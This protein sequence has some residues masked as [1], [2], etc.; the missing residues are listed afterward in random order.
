MT[1]KQIL[2]NWV[3]NRNTNT[4]ILENT[5]VLPFHMVEGRQMSHFYSLTNGVAEP[6]SGLG[7]VEGNHVHPFPGNKTFPSDA[8]SRLGIVHCRCVFGACKIIDATGR[9]APHTNRVG[10][11]VLL[12][13]VLL[14]EVE[15]SYSGLFLTA[16]E[17][18]W[19]EPP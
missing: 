10:I 11:P 19:T 9:E 15:T 1:C 12:T 8:C 16:S 13:S 7:F 4:G 6:C 17:F 18:R 14:V 3:S 5:V 2:S